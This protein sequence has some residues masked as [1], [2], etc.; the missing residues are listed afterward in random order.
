MIFEIL[1][2]GIY[3]ANC[4]IIGCKDTNEVFIV[5]PGGGSDIILNEINKK[6]LNVKYIILT[7]GHGDHIGGII[8][9]KN[10]INAP[11]LIHKDDEDMLLDSSLNLTSMMSIDKIEIKPDRLLEDNDIIN[12]GN[13]E[14]KI[15]HTPGHTKGSICIKVKNTLIT[16]DTLFKG[17]IGRS[18]LYG[19]D[20]ETLINS[21]KSKLLILD[22]DLKVYP[23]HGDSST[24][25]Y[26]KKNNPF[27]R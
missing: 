3:S 20:H 17:S 24:I 21:I 12:I 15:I 14:A 7:H 8:K 10:E 11:I 27:C 6:N 5:D 13:L 9:L 23:G 22:E 2:I 18:D 1:P 16:G 25:K 26:E 4:Y 19:G